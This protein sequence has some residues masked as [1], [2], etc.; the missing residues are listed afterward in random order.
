[1]SGPYIRRDQLKAGTMLRS[2]SDGS[3]TV[4]LEDPPTGFGGTGFVPAYDFKKRRSIQREHS[5]VTSIDDKKFAGPLVHTSQW[6]WI[7]PCFLEVY[8]P[9]FDYDS[10][11]KNG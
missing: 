3:L 10:E 9:N 1:M 4:I 11:V 2:K 5:L 7:K 8:K 6:G